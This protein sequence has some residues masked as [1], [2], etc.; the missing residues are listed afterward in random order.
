MPPKEHRLEGTI[1]TK[2]NFVKKLAAAVAL[3]A[4]A[5]SAHAYYMDPMEFNVSDGSTAAAAS[6]GSFATW[7][8]SGTYSE[9][10]FLGAGTFQSLAVFN[11]GQYVDSDMSSFINDTKLNANPGYK[12]YATMVSTGTYTSV[13]GVTTFVSNTDT[14]NLWLD[15]N[16][17]TVKNAF[18]TFAAGITFTST[19]SPAV[20]TAADDKLLGSASHVAAS[21]ANENTTGSLNGQFDI[22]FS[23]WA[24]TTNGKALFGNVPMKDLEVAGNFGH[25]TIPAVGNNFTA[26][27]NGTANA[28]MAPEP[29]SLALFGIGVLGLVGAVARRNKSK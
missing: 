28:W 10:V 22:L 21:D 24:L 6:G 23:N 5:V 25:I 4:T 14:L 15:P 19:G 7:Q 8:L 9:K 11:V 26:T 18:S 2:M 13:N 3:A 1:M 17:N 29:G 12:M 16:R 27:I 20:S